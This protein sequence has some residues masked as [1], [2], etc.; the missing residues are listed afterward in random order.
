MIECAACSVHPNKYLT[1]QGMKTVRY[2]QRI[3]NKEYS[4]KSS[5]N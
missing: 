4:R 5:D 2:K 3:T 1:T